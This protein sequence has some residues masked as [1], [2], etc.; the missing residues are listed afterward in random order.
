MKKAIVVA[1]ITLFFSFWTEP[2]PA[3]SWHQWNEFII[4][5]REVIKKIHPSDSNDMLLTIVRIKNSKSVE[6]LQ[7]SLSELSSNDRLIINKWLESK[8]TDN[9]SLQDDPILNHYRLEAG[10][11]KSRLEAA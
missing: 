3:L 2:A 5:L 10:R 1:M 4:K 9:P 11:L 8:T 6:S 7:T